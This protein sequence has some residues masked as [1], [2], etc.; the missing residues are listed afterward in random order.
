MIIWVALL[1]FVKICGDFIIMQAVDY[2]LKKLLF[3]YDCVTIPGLGGF[4]MQ[5]QAATINHVRNRINPPSR[6]PSFNS[7]LNHDDGLLISSVARHEHITYREAGSV[8]S[9]FVEDCK[10]RIA[11]GENFILEG[12]GELSSG[13]DSGIRFRQLDRSN[14]FAGAFGME[15]LTLYPI[16]RL[17]HPVRLSQKP[18][19]RKLQPVKERKP[20]SV[21]WTLI[22][23]VPVILF[24]LYG[25]IFPTSIQNFYT[26]Y[27]GILSDF[28]YPKGVWQPVVNEPVSSPEMPVLKIQVSDPVE[29]PVEIVKTALPQSP[30]YYV[31][32]GCFEREENAGKFLSDLLNRGFEAEKAGTN[33]RGHIRIS[34]KSFPDKASALPYLNHVRN[35][36]NASAWLL[37]Y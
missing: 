21:K 16:S 34:Y 6:I 32:G 11:A 33:N 20:A 30:R 8:V 3:E 14:F 15:A 19:D 10:L 22:L 12:I 17:K 29:L 1:T 35:E 4:I 28:G 18:V 24:L 31:I 26:N 5:S 7:L 23:S 9:E 37:K 36:E 2:Y 27:T 13:S 25:I